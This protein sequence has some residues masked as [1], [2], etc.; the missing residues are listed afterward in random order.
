M[1]LAIELKRDERGCFARGEG[2]DC[3][4]TRVMKEDRFVGEAC[5]PWPRLGRSVLRPGG[6]LLAKVVLNF[7]SGAYFFLRVQPCRPM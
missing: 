3:K 1:P 7:F 5:R 6:R 4:V 2:F